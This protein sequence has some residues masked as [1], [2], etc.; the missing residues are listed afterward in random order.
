MSF[1]LELKRRNVVKVGLAYAVVAWLLIQ[2]ITTVMPTFDAPEWVAQTITFLLI[3]L[4]PFVLVF[5]WAFE[6]TPEG[7]KKTDSV[8]AEQSITH[9]TS[10][11]LSY[12]IAALL[13]IAITFVGVD[14]WFLATPIAPEEA[15]AAT[16]APPAAAPVASG[17]RRRS[18]DADAAELGGRDSV[19]ESEPTR[20]GR[21]LRRGHSRRDPE[22][23]RQAAELERHRAYVRAAVRRH[24]QDDSGDRPRAQRR[25]RHGRQR[26]LR[27]RPRARD[28]A[29]HRRADQRSSVVRFIRTGI[30]EHL[31]HSGGHRD[32]RRER[33]ASRI[34]AG[35][36][37]EHRATT[38][39]LARGLRKIISPL[40]TTRESQ[41]PIR[42]LSARWSRSMRPWRSTPRSH[43]LG[44]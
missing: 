17:A 2:M 19:R 30:R 24:E 28:D 16:V 40:K 32:E 4:L 33:A 31:C 38:H 22:P 34:H 14:R 29:A 15:Q 7:L 13:V 41:T 27:R 6:L 35:R 39:E 5:A 1:W 43:A 18:R 8:P 9:A 23:A 25:N 36:A 37:G 26:P 12:V 10:Q 21:L 42:A 11:R 3:L 44:R 20:G